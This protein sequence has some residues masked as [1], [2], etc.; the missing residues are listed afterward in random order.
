MPLKHLCW[1]STQFKINP[2]IVIKCLQQYYAESAKYSWFVL[3]DNIKFFEL[4]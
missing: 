4:S 1:G 3:Q 2:I